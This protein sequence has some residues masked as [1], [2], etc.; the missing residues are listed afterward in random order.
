MHWNNKCLL[1]LK[2][3]IWHVSN[4]NSYYLTLN[5]KWIFFYF[6]THYKGSR[7]HSSNE[8]VYTRYFL[9][10]LQ[11]PIFSRVPSHQRLTALCKNCLKVC[12]NTFDIFIPYTIQPADG[13]CDSR[14]RFR[15]HWRRSQKSSHWDYF[16]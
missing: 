14:I 4:K 12:I 11:C 6:I 7:A 13:E 15:C 2:N 5:F 9:V 10:Y 3:I 1:R 16:S 8:F